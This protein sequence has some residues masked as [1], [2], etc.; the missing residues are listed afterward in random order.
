[1][2][3]THWPP[4]Y[5]PFFLLALSDCAELKCAYEHAFSVD[6]DD[7]GHRCREG[8]EVCYVELAGR[9]DSVVC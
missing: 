4:R 3:K 6:F 1:M 8:F 9:V 7:V 2:R 5:L